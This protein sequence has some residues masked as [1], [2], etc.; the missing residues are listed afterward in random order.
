MRTSENLSKTKSLNLQTRLFF[1]KQS[2]KSVYPF[3][4][5]ST[6]RIRDSGITLTKNMNRL[7]RLKKGEG[8][9]NERE[10]QG[11]KSSLSSSARLFLLSSHF[12]IKWRTG[13]L[14]CRI[15]M[16]GVV[17]IP[18]PGSARASGFF[19]E[20][21]QEWVFGAGGGERSPEVIDPSGQSG[22]TRVDLLL[23]FIPVY[24]PKTP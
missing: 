9:R 24:F 11:D 21:R 22:A 3:I 23:V 20:A 19:F 6:K 5:S 16:S 13:Q 2:G 7:L 14:L 4:H 12:L 15:P 18:M 10:R 8:E 17:R 1:L